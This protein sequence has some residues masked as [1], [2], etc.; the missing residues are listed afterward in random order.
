[1]QAEAT[2]KI[3]QLAK[4]GNL[5]QALAVMDNLQAAGVQ[6]DAMAATALV[7][8]CVRCKN[9]PEAERVFESLFDTTGTLRPDGIAVA[10]LVRGLG[11]ASPP[12]WIKIQRLL[13]RLENEYFIKLTVPVYNELLDICVKTNDMDKGAELLDKMHAKEISPDFNTMEVIKRKRILR[14][15]LKKVFADRL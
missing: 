9:L 6:P 10:V 3:R 2:K 14:S 12:Q 13:A 7:D 8:C 5:A 1:M 11:A 15:H 4:S